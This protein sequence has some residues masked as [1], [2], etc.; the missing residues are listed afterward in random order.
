MRSSAEEIMNA[1][2]AGP[3]PNTVGRTQQPA[4][5]PAPLVRYSNY[6]IYCCLASI[7]NWED[8]ILFTD[9]G[10]FHWLFNIHTVYLLGIPPPP[11]GPPAPMLLVVLSR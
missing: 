7:I 6:T 9:I 4:D 1:V 8:T 11:T 10:I 2:W 5:K 3:V